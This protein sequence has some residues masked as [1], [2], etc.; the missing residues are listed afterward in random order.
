MSAQRHSSGGSRITLIT[1]TLNS[2]Q[3]LSSTLLSV[4]R[5]SSYVQQHIVVDG[6][7]RDATI[8]LLRSLAWSGLQVVHAPGSSASEAINAGLD[9]VDN[10]TLAVGVLNSDDYLTPNALATTQ[11]LLQSNDHPD[12]ISGRVVV[13]EEG[14]A[15]RVSRPDRFHAQHYARGFV[16]VV[17]PSTFVRWRGSMTDIRYP[18]DNR[19]CWDGEYLVRLAVAGASFSVVTD[20]LAVFRVHSEQI[21]A[22]SDKSQYFADRQN[23]FE[24]VVGRV[25]N[26]LDWFLLRHGAKVRRGFDWIS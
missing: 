5:Q 25:P 9:R 8:P 4:H 7:S 11:N 16:R 22:T 13:R 24:Q 18:D 20:V 21:S 15:T 1:P 19:T 12:V 6:G 2:E 17:H 10:A 14:G 26:R 3:Y 23:I